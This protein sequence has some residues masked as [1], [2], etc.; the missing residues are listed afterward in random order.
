MSF[1]ASILNSTPN[2]MPLKYECSIKINH[3]IRHVYLNCNPRGDSVNV[4]AQVHYH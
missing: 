3:R 1:M 2:H 4:A